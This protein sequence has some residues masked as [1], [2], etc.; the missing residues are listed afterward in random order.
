VKP[1][2]AHRLARAGSVQPRQP[3]KR[4]PKLTQPSESRHENVAPPVNVPGASAYLG[5]CIFCRAKTDQAAAWKYGADY[6]CDKNKCMAIGKKMVGFMGF[7]T[8]WA[9][10]GRYRDHQRELV[11]RSTSGKGANVARRRQGL[12]TAHHA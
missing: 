5:T 6:V 9:A 11:E 1:A 3:T 12:R 4:K 10:V 7:Y 2:P 8:M